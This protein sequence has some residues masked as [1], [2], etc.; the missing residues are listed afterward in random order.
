MFW[1]KVDNKI[2]LREKFWSSCLAI[3][4]KPNTITYREDFYAREESA[5]Y[6]SV[7]LQN[8]YLIFT[9]S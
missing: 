4:S 2:E 8:M 6:T 5:A 7:N 3:E 9:Y 1:M